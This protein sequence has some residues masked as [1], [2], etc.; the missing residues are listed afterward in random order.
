M[1]FNFEE[2][3]DLQSGRPVLLA[4]IKRTAFYPDGE[5]SI[6]YND[7]PP[8]SFIGASQWLYKN[9]PILEDA[10]VGQDSLEGVWRT[11][12]V[13]ETPV[14]ERG[15]QVG[16]NLTQRLAKGY[17]KQWSWKSVRVRQGELK[18]GNDTTVNSVA[19]G[20]SE[21]YQRQAILSLPYVEA[22]KV[23][24][25]VASINSVSYTDLVAG[26]VSFSGV[27][28]NMGAGYQIEEDQTVTVLLRLGKPQYTVEGYRG[29]D[30]W[31]GEQAY[32]VSNVPQ[33]RVQAVMDAWKTINGLPGGDART[34]ANA[35]IMGGVNPDANTANIILTVPVVKEKLNQRVSE[36]ETCFDTT[37][38]DT[39][40]HQAAAKDQ[41]EFV[42]GSIVTVQTEETPLGTFHN[43][44]ETRTDEQDVESQ[45]RHT[46]S[47][48]EEQQGET[49]RN[50]KSPGFNKAAPPA[51]EA[52][53]I[54]THRATRTESCLWDNDEETRTATRV[55]FASQSETE[56][57][58]ETRK[59]DTTRFEAE[60]SERDITTLQGAG[61]I[62]TQQIEKTEFLDR[63]NDT[64]EIRTATQGELGVGIEA[65]KTKRI[66]YF[67]TL[68]SE[69]ER[70][71]DNRVAEETTQ[72]LGTIKTTRSSKND[73]DLYDNTE[74]DR[75]AAEGATAEHTVAR[76]H[77]NTEIKARA[78][79][80][81]DPDNLPEWA[82]PPTEPLTAGTGVSVR[83]R[84]NEFKGVS[85]ERSETVVTEQRRPTTGLH[86]ITTIDGTIYEVEYDNVD[87]VNLSTRLGELSAYEATHT[88]SP[89]LRFKPETG[90]Y[91]LRLRAYPPRGSG[92]GGLQAFDETLTGYRWVKKIVGGQLLRQKE[93]YTHGSILS[94]ARHIVKGFIENQGNPQ[95]RQFKHGEQTWYH[96]SYQTLTA[97]SAFAANETTVP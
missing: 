22:D 16:V 82:I 60:G 96:G 9:R 31:E 56:T 33:A 94:P 2:L 8:G 42:Q 34:G 28:F 41:P 5:A 95:M 53:T 3:L 25:V 40:L 55:P 51:Q 45:R 26:G 70:N 4:G 97:L 38:S 72:T 67:E 80:H 37:S 12:D 79:A 78:S 65:G 15:T 86:S 11:V 27:W 93:T 89:D 29:H 6:I 75:V 88:I 62:V 23:E 87:P 63:T 50:Q 44:T 1:T 90:T 43:T 91:D 39:H 32:Y 13:T 83:L 74:E 76:L 10:E 54:V 19:I 48:F 66:N 36:R 21:L 69:T 7:L 57:P 77:N 46:E 52:G 71:A 20:N 92:S 49:T 85:A 17:H 59:S 35:T 24:S 68:T 18:Q 47:A 64:V 14:F 58:F 81:L 73:F 30:T 84:A 61:K